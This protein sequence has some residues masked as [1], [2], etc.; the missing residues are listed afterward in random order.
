VAFQVNSLYN[1]SF[2]LLYKEAPISSVSYKKSIQALRATERFNYSTIFGIPPFDNETSESPVE[3]TPV[4]CNWINRSVFEL[5]NKTDLEKTMNSSPSSIDGIHWTRIIYALKA[6][7]ERNITM[8]PEK[9][10]QQNT[11]SL[12]VVD[13]A[14][15]KLLNTSQFDGIAI[16]KNESYKLYTKESSDISQMNLSNATL[17]RTSFECFHGFPMCVFISINNQGVL[18]DDNLNINIVVNNS[19]GGHFV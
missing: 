17:V 14:G 16:L 2:L 8:I 6:I 13:D 12:L 19:M 15:E 5:F 3:G 1:E 4:F 10:S 7:P 18:L 11:N 9:N